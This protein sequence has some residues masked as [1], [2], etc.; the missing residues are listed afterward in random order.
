VVTAC[1]TAHGAILQIRRKAKSRS[2]LRKPGYGVERLGGK[3]GL[4]RM[5]SSQVPS[6]IAVRVGLTCVS[7]SGVGV[8]AIA[9][10]I[11]FCKIQKTK[12]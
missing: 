8:L 7:T 6:A 1:A 9:F 4:A 11:R 2:G 3:G 10:M 5:R 12:A